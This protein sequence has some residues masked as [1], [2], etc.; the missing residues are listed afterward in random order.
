MNF[1]SWV[2]IIVLLLSILGRVFIPI[3]QAEQHQVVHPSQNHTSVQ[4]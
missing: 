2:I 4:Q 1:K 3:M